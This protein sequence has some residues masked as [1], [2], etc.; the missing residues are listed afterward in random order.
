MKAEENRGDPGSE[1]EFSSSM[2]AFDASMFCRSM[3]SLANSNAV[4]L[5][6]W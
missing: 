3:A 5:P 6:W 4:K 1:S 2:P